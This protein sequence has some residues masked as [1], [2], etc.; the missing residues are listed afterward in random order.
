MPTA[1]KKKP[2]RYAF[3]LQR[4]IKEEDYFPLFFLRIREE[5]EKA[6]DD[7]RIYILV[8][9]LQL[10]RQISKIESLERFLHDFVSFAK[11]V[12]IE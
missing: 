4:A 1:T 2:F 5:T 9:G 3:N 8:E 6:D 10:Y 7:Y 12:K 11:N